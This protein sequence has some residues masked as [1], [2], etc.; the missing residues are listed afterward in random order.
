TLLVLAGIGRPLLFASVD[1]DVAAAAGVP[2]R[3]LA[4]VFLVTLGMAVAIASQVVGALLVFALLVVPAATAHTLTA[5]TLPGLALAVV[6]GLVVT[7]LGLAL[8]YFSD[9]PVGFFVTSIAFGAYVLAQC[10]RRLHHRF[11]R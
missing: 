8:S 10:T 9:R 11:A 5:R 2:V 1:P 4:V 3:A 6:I 7:S